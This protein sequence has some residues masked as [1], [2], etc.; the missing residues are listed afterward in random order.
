VAILDILEAYTIQT[1]QSFFPRFVIPSCSAD[2]E[3]T[4]AA[5]HA[6]LSHSCTLY[7]SNGVTAIQVLANCII[8]AGLVTHPTAYKLKVTV[9]SSADASLNNNIWSF[10]STEPPSIVVG[11]KGDNRLISTKVDNQLE[12]IVQPSDATLIYK[13]QCFDL[14][15]ETMCLGT[16]YQYLQLPNEASVNVG[17]YLLFPNRDYRMT[18]LATDELGHVH[19][20]TALWTAVN[21]DIIPMSIDSV[22][23]SNLFI[24]VAST[25]TFS[26][27]VLNSTFQAYTNS[28]VWSVTD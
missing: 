16:N 25:I 22:A 14:L 23:N 15:Q 18:L 8:T 12:A 20:A 9:T 1:T 27:I 11:I 13:W 3:A 4:A 19:E 2:N 24:D 17:Q 5:G 21:T 26:A 7:Q 10:L 28:F 6:A